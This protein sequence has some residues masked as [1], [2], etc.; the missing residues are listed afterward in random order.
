[1]NL[2]LKDIKPNV[3]IIDYEWWAFVIFVSLMF[4]LLIYFI[5]KYIK[6]K[7]KKNENLAKLQSLD[8][9]NSK[10]VAYEFT[11]LA[12][13]FVNETNKDL[14]EEIEKELINYKYKPEVPALDKKLEE[15]IKNFIKAIK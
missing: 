9:N 5:Y 7:A 3:A 13:E 1:M 15:K 14:F 4:L 2:P 11:K 10:K 8:F 12:K 6:N